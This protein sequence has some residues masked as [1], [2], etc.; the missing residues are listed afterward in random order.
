M[1]D[2]LER[3]QLGATS[4]EDMVVLVLGS[5]RPRVPYQAALEIAHA[6]RVGAKQSARH[7]RAR[8]S[9]VNELDL[10]DPRADTPAP[11]PHFR[12]SRQAPDVSKWE[13]R[14]NPPLVAL[15][16][17]GVST[18]FDYEAAARLSHDVRHV[19]HVAKAWAG[20]VSRVRRM[21]GNLN[22]A[23]DNYRLGL[24]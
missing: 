18:E 9:F 22:D 10:G 14:C 23:E 15:I 12:R 3:M 2:V 1:G 17:D 13:V 8:A 5:L 21:R 20:D 4:D 6:L 11:H 16:L 7:D 19:S 24:A